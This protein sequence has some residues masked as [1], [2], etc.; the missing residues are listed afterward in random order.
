MKK[1]LLLPVIFLMILPLYEDS[2]G[3]EEDFDITGLQP[4]PPYGIFSVFSAESLPKGNIAFSPG[5]EVLMDPDFYRFL[6][7]A[8]Y[9]ITDTLEF[10]LTIPYV[11]QWADSVD[12]FEDIAFGLKYRFFDEGKYGP[13]LAYI[14]NASIPSGRDGFSTEGRYGG[15]IILTKRVGPVIGHANIFFE[16]PGEG[17]LDEEIFFGA[18]LDFAASHNF[19]FLAELNFKKNHDTKEYDSLEGRIGYRVKTDGMIYTTIGA[20]FDLKNRG[21]DFRITFSITFVIPPGRK[22]IKKVYEEE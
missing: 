6:F 2:F 14:L 3:I 11:H 17:G 8:A 1:H 9:G 10:N 20:G 12:G 21:P 4:V 18:G 13:S 22:A 16:E 15:G 7:K 19:K 5:A